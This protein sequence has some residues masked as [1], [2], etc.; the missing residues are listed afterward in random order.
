MKDG[1][2]LGHCVALRRTSLQ[3]CQVKQGVLAP[4]C[5]ST[6]GCNLPWQARAPT[7][8]L[9]GGLPDPHVP[10]GVTRALTAEVDHQGGWCG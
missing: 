4:T 1:F 8:I 2:W 7:L 6:K 3:R 9:P 5:A 10:I